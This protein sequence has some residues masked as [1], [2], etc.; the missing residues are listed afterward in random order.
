MLYNDYE[1]GIFILHENSEW[2][3]PFRAAFQRA[4]VEF[5][6]WH[7]SKG[8]IDLFKEPP[9]G[10][11]WSRLSASSHTRGH[12]DSKEYGRAVLSWLQSHNR[13]VINGR[14]VLEFEVSKV[15]QYLA[16]NE[17]GFRTPYSIAVFGKDE[18]LVRAQ[19]L[20]TPFITKHNQ[21]G[22]GLG[23]KIFENLNSFR[24]YVESSDFE[25]SIDGITILQ[26]YIESKEFFITRLEFIGG[27]FHYAVR[28]DTS[29]GAFELCP[30]DSC[31]V[32]PSLA[33]G[34]CDIRSKFSLRSDVDSNII[35]HLEKFLQ[36]HNIDIAGI[37]FIE[38]KSGEIVIYDINTNTNYNSA[39]ESSVP[40]RAADRVVEFLRGELAKV[41]V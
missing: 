27:R 34:A 20:K 13:R 21:G 1:D 18:L 32:K 33:G 41:G 35:R 29:D 17:A 39:V 4:G 16:L 5:R 9:K 23:V 28:V 37:E 24:D 40:H 25:P 15:S 11:F 30:A 14:S 10:V 38:S 36:S 3:E 22:K 6:D 19:G 8:S 2:I 12:R 31:E 26:E 7:L